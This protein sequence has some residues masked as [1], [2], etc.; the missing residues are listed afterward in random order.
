MLSYGGRWDLPPLPPF[1]PQ[2]GF[3]RCVGVVGVGWGVGV[4]LVFIVRLRAFVCV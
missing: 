1:P 4:C 2:R 3:K